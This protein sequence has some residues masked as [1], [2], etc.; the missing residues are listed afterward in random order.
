MLVCMLG[1]LRSG[2][3]CGLSERR[4]LAHARHVAD[5][6]FDAVVSLGGPLEGSL[7]GPLEGM[8]SVLRIPEEGAGA[9]I[10]DS[11][12]AYLVLTSGSTGRPK[13]VG[14][15]HH[16]IA[17]YCS[18]LVERLEITGPV[19]CG[20]VSSLEADLGNTALFIAW[21]TGGAIALANDMERRDPSAFW[22]WLHECGVEL[23]KIT[24]S[25]WQAVLPFRGFHPK[26]RPLK[27][28]VLGGERFS[29][30]LA[31]STLTSN[32]AIQIWNHY[33]P[34]ETTIGVAAHHVRDVNELERRGHA[35]VP[36]GCALGATQLLIAVDGAPACAGQGELLIG[37]PGVCLGYL[38][39]PDATARSFITLD[40]RPAERYYKSG[41]QVRLGED[42]VVEF[43]GRSDRQVKL[44][45]Y[46]VQL[47]ELE[48]T[49]AALLGIQ[50]VACLL[51]FVDR[52][53][54][55]VAV[56]CSPHRD[57]R[58][59]MRELAIGLD[60]IVMP[61]QV[62][63]L[64]HWPLNA[65]GKTDYNAIAAL[66][67]KRMARVHA[68]VDRE[69]EQPLVAQLKTLWKHLLNLDHVGEDDNF[70]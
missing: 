66:L 35:S 31:R 42:G 21:W 43:I 32:C 4:A 37:G 59:L 63:R 9:T 22:D 30:E 27:F 24:P 20:H 65:N 34:S 33:G 6:L 55:A 44:N 28:L 14:I 46:R 40:G 60:P 13:A 67:E 26:T 39:D 45:G 36:V 52:A 47:D 61:S 12:L 54:L 2:A 16:N 62:I 25:H 29:L 49:I 5:G 3:A 64:D 38:N 41:D 1:V 23:L 48:E 7:G 69:S 17:H 51:T 11:R 8:K 56:L 57:P 19:R 18:A 10:R 15:T 53:H 50:L 58:Q 70:F 68:D